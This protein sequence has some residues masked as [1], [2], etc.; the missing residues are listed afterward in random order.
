[1]HFAILA[2]K[3]IC[4][5]RSCIHLLGNKAPWAQFTFVQNVHVYAGY[6]TIEV[7]MYRPD[8]LIL[9]YTRGIVTFT[10]LEGQQSHKMAARGTISHKKFEKKTRWAHRKP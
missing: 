2:V 3:S 5:L 7:Y 10:N 8:V 1:M 6:T 9:Q 4:S